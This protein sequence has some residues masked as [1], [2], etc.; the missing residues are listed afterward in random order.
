M[1]FD[2][3]IHNIAVWFYIVFATGVFINI[4]VLGATLKQDIMYYNLTR[5]NEDITG[6][7]KGDKLLVKQFFHTPTEH[8]ENVEVEWTGNCWRRT[9]DIR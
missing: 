2:W 5:F 7:Q 8:E 1:T 9:D 4:I 6:N 3:I